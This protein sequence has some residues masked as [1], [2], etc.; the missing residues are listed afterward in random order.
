M[1][2]N[3]HDRRPRTQRGVALLITIF[4]LMLLSAVALAM[5]FRANM[6]SDI[7][8]NFR[9]SQRAYQGARSGLEY[10]RGRMVPANNDI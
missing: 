3:N 8:Q 5:I 2:K 6:E 9:S 1:K 10:V 7:N 4:A